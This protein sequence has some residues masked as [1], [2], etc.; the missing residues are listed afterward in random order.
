MK[1]CHTG[2]FFTVERK[3]AQG[4]D[5]SLSRGTND[6]RQTQITPP[7]QAIELCGSRSHSGT[8]SPTTTP[9]NCH[10]G[11]KTYEPELPPP[12]TSCK[13]I[14]QRYRS[15]RCRPPG[16]HPQLS[17]RQQTIVR[18]TQAG[19]SAFRVFAQNAQNV[20]TRARHFMSVLQTIRRNSSTL[21][22]C[23]KL[24]NPPPFLPYLHSVLRG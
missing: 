20:P 15:G 11:S 13:Y 17:R 9:E 24:K 22:D 3:L 12:A 7:G 6:S 18:R 21:S 4:E 23:T 5:I 19:A 16:P 2:A 8:L 14:T 10:Y 1:R